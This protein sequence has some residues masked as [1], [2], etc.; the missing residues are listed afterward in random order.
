[1]SHRALTLWTL[2]VKPRGPWAVPREGQKP[3]VPD[4]KKAQT[5]P[6]PSLLQGLSHL[7]WDRRQLCL[8]SPSPWCPGFMRPYGRHREPQRTTEH[9]GGLRHWFQSLFMSS[10]QQHLLPPEPALEGASPRGGG[11]NRTGALFSLP[12]A[13]VSGAECEWV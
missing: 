10:S 7:L 5:G 13:Q 3:V 1:M 12:Q 2:E 11:W 4:S 8:Y 6:T 9:G